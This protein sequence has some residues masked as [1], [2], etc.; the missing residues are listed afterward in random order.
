MNRRNTALSQ[1]I[2]NAQL[3]HDNVSLKKHLRH[4][5]MATKRNLDIQQKMDDIGQVVI[6]CSDLE[7]L[8]TEVTK[9]IKV[10]FGL[11][12]VTVTLEESYRKM[13]PSLASSSIGR[14]SPL[15]ESL[16]LM[17]RE[18]LINHFSNEPTPLLQGGVEYGD[19]DFFGMKLFRR[20]RS[21][22]FAPLFYGDNFIGSLNLGSNEKLRYREKDGADFLK[23]LA[24]VISLAVV[25]IELKSW[26]ENTEK[27][28]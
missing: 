16:F 3:R 23:R 4:L 18:K 9:V 6:K 10:D 28:V 15:S 1:K 17:D 7:S 2:S 27:K 26:V 20:I 22:A 11:T 13:L 12:V 8:V 19:V 5:V 21:Q 14:A 25:N 24:Q